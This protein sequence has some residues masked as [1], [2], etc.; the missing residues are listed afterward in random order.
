MANNSEKHTGETPFN[1]K[2]PLAD[3]IS[4]ADLL[5]LTGYTKRGLQHL[6][7]TKVITPKSLPN[8]K[9]YVY[10]RKEIAKLLNSENRTHA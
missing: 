8:G 2:D 1:E 4:E 5:Q 9:K 10:S 7:L 3:F 6:R